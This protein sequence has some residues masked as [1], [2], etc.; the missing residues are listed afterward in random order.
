MLCARSPP[1]SD[2]GDRERVSSPTLRSVCLSGQSVAS[3][4]RP[5]AGTAA[6]FFFADQRELVTVAQA[7]LAA[8][9]QQQHGRRFLKT[10]DLPQSQE[11]ARVEQER[12]RR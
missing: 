5:A 4:G 2:G 10:E 6:N 1:P 12:N 7:N 3:S 11:Y 8:S 9:L